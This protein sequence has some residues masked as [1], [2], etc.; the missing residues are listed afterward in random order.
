MKEKNKIVYFSNYKKQ[1]SLRKHTN[2]YNLICTLTIEI[3]NGYRF[4]CIYPETFSKSEIVKIL[5]KINTKVSK[6]TPEPQFK[7]EELLDV[8]K[9]TI[10]YLE[11]KKNPKKFKFICTNPK[12]TDWKLYIILC[13]LGA[14]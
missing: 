9:F 3:F 11:H 2:K 1:H 5:N 14:K 4:N 6:A 7:F 8:G 13:M 10:F 12:I